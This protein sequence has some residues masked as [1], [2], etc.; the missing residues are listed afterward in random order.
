[1]LFRS[2][3]TNPHR[4]GVMFFP[5]LFPCHRWLSF[6]LREILWDT[7]AHLKEEKQAGTICTKK[8]YVVSLGRSIWYLSVSLEPIGFKYV[9]FQF[10]V[11]TIVLVQHWHLLYYLRPF[12]SEASI[13]THIYTRIYNAFGWVGLQSSVVIQR[14]WLMGQWHRFA[15][16]MQNFLL[17][18]MGFWKLN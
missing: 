9:T 12:V 16:I 5:I 14:V 18:E 8:M 4:K 1:M 11:P 13:F 3:R 15:C 7:R 2:S 6:R 17:N 10:Q